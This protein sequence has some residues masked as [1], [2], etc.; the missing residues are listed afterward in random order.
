[1]K[2]HSNGDWGFNQVDLPK[3]SSLFSQNSINR[4]IYLVLLR[5]MNQTLLYV[6]DYLTNLSF[7]FQTVK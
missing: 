2:E 6:S 3:G 4:F 5:L 1:M 7:E